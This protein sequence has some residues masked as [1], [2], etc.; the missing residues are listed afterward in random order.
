MK[1]FKHQFWTGLGAGVNVRKHIK[2]MGR[3]IHLFTWLT[4]SQTSVN[5]RGLG[6]VNYGKPVKLKQIS[7]EMD[8]V[9]IRTLKRWVHKLRL[10]GYITTEYHSKDGFLVWIMKAKVKTRK[11]ADA[12]MRQAHYKAISERGPK[13]ARLGPQVAPNVGP[14]RPQV[15]PNVV[16]SALHHVEKATLAAESNPPITKVLSYY[17][18]D[19]R[20]DNVRSFSSVLEEL[21]RQTKLPRQE[22]LTESQ[23]DQRRRQLLDQAELL[24]KKYPIRERAI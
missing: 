9:P 5:D 7:Y 6:V 19:T 21:K 10:A 17:N 20:T 12:K 23:L 16:A 11:E 14:S 2:A 1:H 13:P 4:T 3:S 15:A 22:A 18:K 8:G 24:S